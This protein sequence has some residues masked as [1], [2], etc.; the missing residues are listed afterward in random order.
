MQRIWV[1]KSGGLDARRDEMFAAAALGSRDAL[2]GE[3]VTLGRSAREDDLARF[4]G[5]DRGGQS[6][7]RIFHGGLCAPPVRV[8][9]TRRIAE[10]LGEIG[11]HRVDHARIDRGRHV[12]VEVDGFAGVGSIS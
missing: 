11:L 4:G 12:M 7:A 9:S 6:L 5:P 2:Q 10:L 1:G 3:V 8:G